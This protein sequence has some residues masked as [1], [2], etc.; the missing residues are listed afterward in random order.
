MSPKIRAV[1]F[2]TGFPGFL[3]RRLVAHLAAQQ[4]EAAIR[5]LVVPDRVDEAKRCLDSLV[6]PGRFEILSGD[7]MDMHLGLSGAEYA[8]L[9]D[10]VTGIFHLA[11]VQLARPQK[12][13]ARKVNVEGTRNVLELARDC[14]RLRRLSHFSS[15][16][17]SGDRRGVVAEDELEAGQSFRCDYEETK[18]QAEKLVLRAMRELPVTILRPSVVVGDS[19]TGEMDRFD[20]PYALGV[21]LVT[22]PAAVPLPLPGEAVA[23]LHVVPVDYVVQATAAIAADPRAAGRTFHLVDPNP[24]SSRRVYQMVAQRAHRPL[25]RLRVPARAADALL[26]LPLLDRMARPE[27]AALTFLN[28]L[29]FYNCQNTLELLEGTGIRCPPIRSYLPKLVAFT[30]DF[31]RRR[32]EETA[33]VEDPLDFPPEGR[34]SPLRST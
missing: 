3:G 9:C 15:A 31:H 18:F 13:L 2:I 21:L 34:T 14:R 25:P 26:R 30:R 8:R 20:G 5:L 24:M 10:E 6:S 17:V 28:Q 16:F 22:S 19:E 11:A 23:P 33:G 7:V 32:R 4:R 1:Y 12:E 27:R 29:V